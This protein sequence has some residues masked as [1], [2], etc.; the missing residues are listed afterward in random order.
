MI[1]QELSLDNIERTWDRIK[2]YVSVTPA[3][4]WQD[5]ELLREFSSETEIYAKLEIFQKTGT[6]KVRGA[7]NSM[8]DLDEESLGRGITAVSAG[9][10]AIA[11]A[12]CASQLGTS[13]HI[14]M[15]ATA[16]PLRIQRAK[17]YGA[18]ITLCETQ[19]EMFERAEMSQEKD[20]RTFIHPYEGPLTVQGS[21]TAGKEFAAQVPQLDAMILPVGGG[22]LAAGFGAALKQIWPDILIYGVEPEGANTMSLSFDAGTTVSLENVH[23]V[24]DSLAPPKTEPYTLDVCR[25]VIEEIILVEDSLLIDAMRL[26]FHD[27]RLAVE[28]AAAATAAALRGPLREKLSGARV[29]TICCGTNLGLEDFWSLVGSS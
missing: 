17:D 10:H 27:L 19:S 29:G 1:Q 14:F 8:L 3:V 7:M 13:S 18:T 20:G 5:G 15:P 2:D 12:Y 28:P 11:S 16:K 22:G 23:S 25:N 6:F 26:I 21:A 24:A 4:R 9:N